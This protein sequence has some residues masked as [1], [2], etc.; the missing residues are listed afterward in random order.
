MAHPTTATY[1]AIALVLTVV[2]LMEFA[3]LY[4][5]GLAGMMVPILLALSAIK[6]ALV[7]LFYMHL[8]FDRPLYRRVFAGGLGLGVLVAVSLMLLSHMPM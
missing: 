4:V 5:H 7:A 6:F 3:V 1:V 2:T 8:R